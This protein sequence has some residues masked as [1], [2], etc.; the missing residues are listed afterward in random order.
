M[1]KRIICFS[2]A[3]CVLISSILVRTGYL[4]LSNN[5][6]VSENYN[7]YALTIDELDYQ[8][9]YSDGSR[10]TNNEESYVAVIRPNEKCIGEVTRFFDYTKAKD[11][12]NQLSNGYPIIIKLD[13]KIDSK[14]IRVFKTHS[15]NYSCKQVISKNSSGLLNYI[16]SPP[17]YL[18]IR[19]SVD[20]K[21]RLLNG[22]N[23]QIINNNYDINNGLKL[24]LNSKIQDIV[25]FACEPMQSGCAIVM[26]VKT[27][28]ILAIVNKPDDTYLNKCFEQYS[29]GSVFKLV[30]AIC[31]IENKVDIKY[32]CNSKINVGDRIFSCQNNHSHNSQNLK[33]ALANS[34]NCY[35]VNLALYLGKDK[36]LKTAKDLGFDN[37]TEF[38]ENWLIKN[39]NLPSK[40]TLNS[41]GQLSLFGFG[42]GE[43]TSS[44]LQICSLLCTIADKGQYNT[45][46]LIDSKC[47]QKQVISNNTSKL[48]LEYMR[49]VVTNGTGKNAESSS[50]KSAGKTATAQ[51][52]QYNNDKEILNTWFAGVYPFDNPKYAIVVMTEN[53]I[54][55]SIDCCPIYRTIVENI[56]KS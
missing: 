38:Y 28:N 45:P 32:T 33:Q 5:Y 2:V 17:K 21:G 41:K 7:Y 31:S 18:K 19:F 56:E 47:E 50:N 22:D 46:K 10:L 13:N 20:A 29:V 44:P 27:C 39:A 4:M 14:Y 35:F 55:G 53:G 52:G 30:T 54:S 51:T 43:L 34:C 8:L 26:D 3:I 12:I 42:Q 11:I 15:S 49:Y 48:M 9:F 25:T 37:Q 40:K 6:T 24:T 16:E 23:G 36:L 1:K